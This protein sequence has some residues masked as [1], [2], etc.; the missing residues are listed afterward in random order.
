[1]CTSN[2]RPF[3]FGGS[4]LLSSAR[5]YDRFLLM[6][7]GEGAIDTTRIMS[8]ET[9]RLAMSNLLPAGVDMSEA[10]VSSEGF[11]ALGSVALSKQP[12]GKGP[13]TFGWSGG[14]GTTGFVDPSQGIRVAGY[15]QF[16]PA[17]AISFRED[18][19][20]AAYGVS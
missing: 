4:G 12:D 6:L 7:A 16:I 18:I 1:M 8:R 9:A 5:D 3:P 15:G 11:G 13:G 17:T 2:L 14:A 10:L 20:K 19:P